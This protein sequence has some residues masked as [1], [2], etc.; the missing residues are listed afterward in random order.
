VVPQAQLLNEHYT[1]GR[2]VGPAKAPT[3]AAGETSD[4]AESPAKGGRRSVGNDS[5]SVSL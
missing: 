1:L 3:L 4:L 5:R 2:F